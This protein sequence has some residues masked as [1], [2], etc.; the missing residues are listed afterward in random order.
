MT[1]RLDKFLCDNA[2][3][4]R[5]EAKRAI[6]R[7][8]ITVNGKIL[9]SSAT[10]VTLDDDIRL[11]DEPVNY[12]GT[13]YFMLHKPS[14]YVCATED[15][16]HPTVIDLIETPAKGLHCAGRLDIDTTGLVLLS[17][18]GQWTHNI[19]SPKKQCDKCYIAT[20]DA[21][22]GAEAIAK[23]E[24]GIFFQAEQ[25]KTRP[26][27]IQRL[28]EDKVEI[29]ISEGMYHQ[30]KRMFIAVGNEVISLHRNAIGDLRL[31]DQLLP[32]EYRALTDA[33]I[34]LF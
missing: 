20:L 12:L 6:K 2:G 26:A 19:T 24:E 3:L 28:T 23:L 18:D 14:A 33:E 31:D 9:T 30:V 5:S 4:T 21:P 7:K 29:I 32:G 25:R 34:A 22:L 10:H 16:L 15:S 8:Q 27:K 13:Q 11:E 17:N 1:F